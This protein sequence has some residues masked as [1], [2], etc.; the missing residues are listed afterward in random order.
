M[1]GGVVPPLVA[2]ATGV[3]FASPSG[4][5][6]G[7]EER[8]GWL[9]WQVRTGQIKAMALAGQNDPILVVVSA[10][11]IITAIQPNTGEMRW[12]RSY[13]L[14][15]Q[16][17]W[18]VASPKEVFFCAANGQVLALSVQDGRVI[19]QRKG[20]GRE[21]TCQPINVLGRLIMAGV[22]DDQAVV[23]ALDGAS[24]DVLWSRQG[25]KGPVWSQLVAHEGSILGR[26]GNVVCSFDLFGGTLNWL[27]R[28]LDEAGLVGRLQGLALGSEGLF[29]ATKLD[30]ENSVVLAMDRGSG[31]VHWASPVPFPIRTGPLWFDDCLF[32]GDVSHRLLGMRQILVRVNGQRINFSSLP[33]FLVANTTYVP[34]REVAESLGWYV[35]WDGKMVVAARGSHKVQIPVWLLAGRGVAPLREVASTLQA[36]VAWEG[37]RLIADVVEKVAQKTGIY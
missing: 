13:P 12:H 17:E 25:G 3:F 23:E 11:G 6:Y 14:A 35:G 20:A 5:L 37:R 26:R 15:E 34:V 36:E 4:E 27:A 24:G 2:G 32:Y 30:D 18:A 33:P 10:D 19:W 7:L 31:A 29:V 1:L 21:I 8:T 28:P 16:V 22:A 9:K